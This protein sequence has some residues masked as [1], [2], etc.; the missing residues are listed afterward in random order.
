MK[1]SL[2]LFTRDLRLHDHP[3]LVA[4]ARASDRVV[5]AFVL[6]DTLLAGRAGAPN[7]LA[8]LLN[9]LEDLDRSL[10]KRGT[11]LVLRRGDV[12]DEVVGLARSCNAGGIYLSEDVSG[13]ARGRQLRLGRECDRE[14]ITLRAFGGITVIPPGELTPAG[15]D[16]Y[17]VFTPYWNAWRATGKREPLSAPRKIHSPSRIRHGKIPKLSDLIREPPVDG[18]PRGG[19]TAGRERL[20]RWLRNGSGRY[21][22]QADDLPADA[23]SH[24]S[25]YLHFGCLSAT[26]VLARV[27]SRGG[28]EEFARQLCWRDFHHQVLAARPDLPYRDYR[29]GRR[30]WK[31]DGRALEAWRLG[32]TG[33][34]IVDAGMRQL[35]REG[36][37]PNRARL[38]VGSFLTK[39]LGIDWRAG[40]DHFEELLVDADLAN[41]RGNWQWVAGTGNDTRPNRVLNPI[42]QARRFDPAGA[43]VRRHVPELAELDGRSIHEPWKLDPDRRTRLAYPD[44][45]VPPPA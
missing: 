17:R 30:R 1:T 16:H 31:S 34:P 2:V 11:R 35:A 24:L 28:L 9:S 5:P 40:A 12:V 18:L 27:D 21:A 32:E 10:R 8:F 41:N 4:A 38:I 3:A 7:R 25:P 44:P 33:Y 20:G 14:G 6:D 15:G 37:L 42:R 29:P 22:D 13:Y 36:F 26:E 43:Y 19:E 45:L 23:T 39:T